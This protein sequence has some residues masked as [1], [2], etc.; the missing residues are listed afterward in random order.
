VLRLRFL[1]L[2]L[3][4]A[5]VALSAC[6]AFHTAAATVDGRKIEEARFARQL[7]F[8]LADPRFGQ[9]FPGAQGVAQRKVEAR[10][11]LTFLIH[12]QVVEEYAAEHGIDV[13]REEIG[14]QV[15][16]LITQL[17]GEQAY[18][19]QIRR[20]GATTPDIEDLL[21]HQLLR[22]KVAEE[23]VA[24]QVSDERLMQTYQE[25]LP[26]FTQV[27]VSHILVRDRAEAQDILQRAT[28]RNFARL[29]REFS[30][31]PSSAPQGGDLG[32]QRPADLVGPFGQATLDIPVGEIGG[33]V[34][35]EFGFHVIYVREREA[36]PFEEVRPQ[37]L[38]E[39]RGEVF[40][41][42]LLG[43]LEE[44]EIR[45]NPRYG[46]FDQA[47]GQVVERTATSPEP[48]VQ[49]TP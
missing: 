30:R 41:D 8:V 12:Q 2:L 22:Q 24:E 19:A 42:W 48:A 13:S 25:R 18:R 20:S 39:V 1:L 28:P 5:A 7:D 4:L 21:R 37:L 40:T 49:V 47:S 35:T 36:Q 34:E 46:Y 27:R 23:V 31:D 17:G 9:Q 33:P 38:E 15:A 10:N 32:L 14:Q 29:A 6:A 44:T 43:R 16:A 45:V 3:L 11:L 26:E